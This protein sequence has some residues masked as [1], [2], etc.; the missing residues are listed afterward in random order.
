MSTCFELQSGPGKA[1]ISQV[2]LDSRHM[3]IYA[4]FSPDRNT[5]SN[6]TVTGDINGIKETL[7]CLA[8]I[9]KI[10]WVFLFFLFF[11]RLSLL[12]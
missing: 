8:H 12:S 1:L 3:G 7:A 6:Y 2:K 4:N 9:N 10:V 11:I 5:S